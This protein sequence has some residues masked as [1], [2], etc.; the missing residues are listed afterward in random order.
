MRKKLLQY[1]N[2][3]RNRGTETGFFGRLLVAAHERYRSIKVRL[4][5]TDN[6]HASRA[7]LKARR[8]KRRLKGK[9]FNFVSVEQA[10]EWTLD[11]VRE[12]PE[13]YDVVVGVPRSGMFIA[14]LIALK[15]GRALTTPDLLAR[16]EYWH[17]RVVKDKLPLEAIRHVLLVD[18]SMD[19]GRAMSRAEEQ[20]R[21][22]P[23]NIR[24]SKACLIV[25]SDKKHDVDLY[26]KLLEPPRVFEWNILHRK[27]ASYF[28]H[29][30][31]AVDMDGVLC[32]D[33]PPG[34]DEDEP[35]YLEWLE[36]A[37]PY[38]IP[39]FEIDAII[40]CRLEKYRPQTVEWLEKHEV[41]YKELCMWGVESKADRQGKFAHH[42]INELLRIKPDMYWESTAIQSEKIW[43]ETR[44]PTLCIDE[45]VLLS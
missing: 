39:A 43:N 8:L 37:R 30:V 6:P 19:S 13:R 12:L 38:L 24:V 15:L 2:E 27:I 41:R 21:A 42:K 14:S 31:L 23:G 25:R 22:L 29:G 5:T 11:W 18:D 32:A 34:I 7:F 33:C 9:E 20:L 3:A 17:S 10:S 28:G 16:G 1:I 40:T 35:R 36:A 44:I 4:K 45:M 26:Y